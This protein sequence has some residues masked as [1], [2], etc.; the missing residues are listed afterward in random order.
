MVKN[1]E[2]KR[3]AI[4][5]LLFQYLSGENKDTGE[6][7]QNQEMLIR[8]PQIRS[9]NSNNCTAKMV[10]LT[11]RRLLLCNHFG[12]H[13]TNGILSQAETVAEY[14]ICV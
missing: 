12:A 3:K 13:H 6:E 9:K 10:L 14:I 8:N 11:T 4:C 1:D 2:L 7:P 5:F